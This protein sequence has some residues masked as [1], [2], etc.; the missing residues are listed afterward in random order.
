VHLPELRFCK[1]RANLLRWAWS[2]CV[3]GFHTLLCWVSHVLASYALP[4]DAPLAGKRYPML[5]LDVPVA[6]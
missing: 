4:L 3:V 6:F 1:R 2:W 5:Q